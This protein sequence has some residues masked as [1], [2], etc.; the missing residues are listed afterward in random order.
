MES[1]LAGC[2]LW[3]VKTARDPEGLSHDAKEKARC[4][5]CRDNATKASSL[6]RT[7]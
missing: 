3:S 5:S 7:L 4:L 6:V 2:S 1:S